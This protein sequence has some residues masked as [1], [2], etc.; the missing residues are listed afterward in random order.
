MIKFDYVSDLHI[1]YWDKKYWLDD[2][3][4]NK[5]DFP[6]EWKPRSNILVIA[7]DISDDITVSLEYIKHVKN[8][9]KKI[10]FIDGNHEHSHL[11]PELIQKNTVKTEK[12]IHYLGDE[13]VII[14]KSVF[15]GACGWWDYDGE[16][17][18]NI[19]EEYYVKKLG[20]EKNKIFAKNVMQRAKEEYFLIVQKLKKY[21]GNPDIDEIVLV[22][23]TVPLEIFSRNIATDFNTRFRQFLQEDLQ[24][25]GVTRWIFGHNHKK[26]HHCLQGNHQK[27]LFLLSNPRGRP[28][29]QD[30][31]S[32]SIKSTGM[33]LSEKDH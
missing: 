33:F 1:D 14:H 32:Y 26:F 24:S 16:K 11:Y 19:E 2:Q 20:K 21:S 9:Y 27:S 15:I 12:D 31:E 3:K 6:F 23:H 10:I 4:E 28:D 25:Y 17:E 30:Q 29:D 18:E 7:G 13:D 22:T 8:F 5:K